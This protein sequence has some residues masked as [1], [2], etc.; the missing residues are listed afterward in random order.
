MNIGEDQESLSNIFGNCSL[1]FTIP[2]PE[3]LNRREPTFSLLC[4]LQ[5]HQILYQILPR[6]FLRICSSTSHATLPTCLFSSSESSQFWCDEIIKFLPRFFFLI[7]LRRYF[8]RNFA[9][10]SSREFMVFD[11][12]IELITTIYRISMSIF[13]GLR[14]GSKLFT[15]RDAVKM[16]NK[17][18]QGVQVNFITGA[19]HSGIFPEAIRD[20]CQKKRL[21]AAASSTDSTATT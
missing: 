13:R 5:W 19:C 11:A 16:C 15:R 8:R 2:S 17:F 7:Y 14:I 6:Y 9:K 10:L 4:R 12:M 18:V 20:S 3:F 1:L 21:T